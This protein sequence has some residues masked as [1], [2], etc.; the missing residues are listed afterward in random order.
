M[1]PLNRVFTGFA[2]AV[3]ATLA[4]LHAQ[5]S[6][7]PRLTPDDLFD[8]N[9]VQDIQLTVNTR[10]WAEL[11]ERYRENVYYQADLRWRGEVVR[12]VGIR[13]R[14][15]GSRSET[16]PG[17]RVDFNRYVTGQQLLGLKSVV[18]DNLTQDP[19]MLKERVVMRFFT[20]MGMPAP[21]VAH[22]RLFV[23]NS[24]AGLYTVVESIDK[25]FLARTL[26]ENDGY[27]Y[28]FKHTDPYGF[29]Y[30]GSELEK[31]AEFFEPK[32]HENDSM[33]SLYRPIKELAWTVSESPDSMFVSA[34]TEYLDLPTFFRYAAVENFLAD[35]D[36]LLGDWGMNNFYLYRFEGKNVSQL[37]PWDK[38]SSFWAVDYGIWTNMEANAL[39]R[40]ALK[41]PPL[42]RVYLETLR[43]CAELALRPPEPAP[44]VARRRLQEE[45]PPPGWLEREV[46]FIYSQ[47][48]EIAAADEAKPFS[49]ERFED[50]SAKVLEFSRARARYVL[51]ETEQR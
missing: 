25:D 10:D 4:A 28:E 16:K 50:E 11:K 13:S 44:S 12:N 20:E 26:N 2:V 18:L 39:A 33:A 51:H 5:T 45:T 14:G 8:P 36:G 35:R 42:Q 23:N 47:I 37:L 32:T 48:R 19:S 24:F 7:A 40:R 46:T 22:V 15:R 49:T 9:T 41:E 6:P 38:D 30:L 27:L 3:L 1:R 21:R 29:E 31:Y 17:L 34:M 43:R